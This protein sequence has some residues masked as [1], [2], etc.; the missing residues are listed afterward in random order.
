M[1][2][3]GLSQDIYLQSWESGEAPVGWRVANVTPVF[4][5]AKK[6]EPDSCRPLGLSLVRCKT[7]EKIILGVTAKHLKDNAVIGPNQ[8]EF[9]KGKSCLTSLISVSDQVMHLAG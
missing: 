3:R 6:E 2:R 8:H 4:K 9:M 7:K 5:K 1:L